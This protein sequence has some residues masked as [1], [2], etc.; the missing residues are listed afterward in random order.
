[1]REINKLDE[2][3]EIVTGFSSLKHIEGNVFALELEIIVN[4]KNYVEHN[5]FPV[6][7]N[8]IFILTVDI[9]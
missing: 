8:T 3:K 2:I 1:M 9:N 4:T 7:E 5:E 6:I